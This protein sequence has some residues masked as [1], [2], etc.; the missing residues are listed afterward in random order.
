[1]GSRGDAIESDEIGQKLVESNAVLAIIESHGLT[2]TSDHCQDL[3][4]CRST[5]SRRN[6]N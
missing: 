6:N 5:K 3:G 2:T 4:D 1:V